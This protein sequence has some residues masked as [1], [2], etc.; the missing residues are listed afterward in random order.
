MKRSS[1]KTVVSEGRVAEQPGASAHE[2]EH[3]KACRC[4]ETAAMKP[5]EL[6][7]L[8]ISD[9]AFWKKAKK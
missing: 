2:S 3:G 6:L 8:M 4:E 9:L 7:K 1:Q 5:R